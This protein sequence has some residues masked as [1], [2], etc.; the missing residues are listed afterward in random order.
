MRL[1]ISRAGHFGLQL[2]ASMLLL[3]I[4]PSLSFAQQTGQAETGPQRETKSHVLILGDSI[5]IGY[6][7]FVKELLK[8]EA[9]VVRPTNANGG[10]ENCNGTTKGIANIDRWLE[11]D[12]GKWDVIHFNFG[13]HDLKHVNP[14]TRAN[15]NNVNDPHQASPEKYEEQLREIVKK[16]KATGAKLVFATTTPV[17]EGKLNPFR[18]P[19]D[20]GIFND[21]A[22][23][24]M[25]EN[26]IPI[27]DLYAFAEPRLTDIQRPANVHFTED[28]SKALAEE[29]A[30]A[31]RAAIGAR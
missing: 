18:L 12:G 16:L 20:V 21:V 17:P 6:T 28:G 5:S 9:N 31:I 2:A 22:R 27:D 13:L 29:V 24:V 7:P 1:R 10:A 19:A 14:E 8:D 15:S 30:K 11:L 25:E 23:K 26:E 4:G 3:L